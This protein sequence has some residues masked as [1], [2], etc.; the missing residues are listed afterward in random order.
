[1]TGLGTVTLCCFLHGS[2]D[3][4]MHA[5]ETKP[6]AVPY[7]SSNAAPRSC[8]LSAGG[9]AACHIRRGAGVGSG[10]ACRLPGA[11]AARGGR[12]QPAAQDALCLCHSGGHC[13][14][15][16]GELCSRERQ[17]QQSRW[18]AGGYLLRLAQGHAA[19]SQHAASPLH[20]WAHARLT[21]GHP[22]AAGS[23]SCVHV[24]LQGGAGEVRLMGGLVWQAC[25]AR[26]SAGIGRP[27]A[28][29]GR[30]AGILHPSLPTSALTCA[31]AMA[32]A[33]AQPKPWGRARQ[34]GLAAN[35][36]AWA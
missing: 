5:G 9:S 3:K 31:V 33:K 6:L 25:G 14:C 29:A 19:G 16:D 36:W 15:G 8:P 18:A 34:P 21:D 35:A 17:G 24:G 10:C 26:L 27:E 11:A 4:Q 1:M 22:V 32:E 12:A 2:A 28:C 30:A 20:K 7:L 23:G 13:T